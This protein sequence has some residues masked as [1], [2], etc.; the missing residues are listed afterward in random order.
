MSHIKNLGRIP[1]MDEGFYLYCIID[2]SEEFEIDLTGVDKLH[3]PY[4]IPYQEVGALVSK[5][6]LNDYNQR[7]L[8]R[9]VRDLEWLQDKADRHETIIEQAMKISTV[10]PITFGTIFEEESELKKAIQYTLSQIRQIFKIIEGHEEWGLKL[11]C[12]FSQLRKTISGLSFEIK[13]LE[14]R[15]KNSSEENS[16]FLEKRLE[17]EL[18][19]KVEKKASDIA[20]KVYEQLAQLATKSH[21]NELLDLQLP[22]VSKIM[23]LNSVY[24]INE[25]KLY[26]FLLKLKELKNKYSNF[27]FYFYHS[28]PWPPYNFSNLEIKGYD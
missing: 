5:V 6:S 3:Q 19:K 9:K 16:N 15:L 20:N 12:N 22:N 8:E 14:T 27:G 18:D 28:G 21:S 2:S 1:M 26:G 10:I 4:I 11:Y 24:L 23:V 7:E 13:E 25:D 17:K